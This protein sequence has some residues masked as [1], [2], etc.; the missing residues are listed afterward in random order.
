MIFLALF[1]M[2]YVISTRINVVVVVCVFNQ[3]RLE[4]IMY[5]Q[6]ILEYFEDFNYR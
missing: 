6:R 3:N 5:Y 4:Y 1:I 2:Y